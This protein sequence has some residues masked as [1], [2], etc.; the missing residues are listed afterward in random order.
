MS[1]RMP[2][3]LLTILLGF[4]ACATQTPFQWNQSAQNTSNAS[5]KLTELNRE[6]HGAFMDVAYRF[7]AVGFPAEKPLELW[8]RNVIRS[9]EVKQGTV[10]VNQQGTLHWLS[11]DTDA[12]IGL[13]GLIVK[14]LHAAA[15]DPLKGKE[16]SITHGQNLIGQQYEWA[17]FDKETS[18]IAIAKVIPFPLIAEGAG[19]C[20]LSVVL[21]SPDGMF[22]EIT[23]ENFQVNEELSFTSQ[24]DEEVFRKEVQYPASGP[25]RM[26]YLPGVIGKHSGE[27]TV[28]FAGKR[29][30]VSRKLN[31]GQATLVVQ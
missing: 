23:V 10:G 12:P 3:A 1:I 30:T 18:R 17:L 26:G 14:G 13:A 5:L 20:R 21:M 24:S 27:A 28:T 9:Y 31:W 4:G 16:L 7:E 6:R 19:G 2:V 15:A 8:M 22:F 25:L 29:C 11:T